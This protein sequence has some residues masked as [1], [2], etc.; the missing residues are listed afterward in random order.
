MDLE[1]S[2]AQAW[3]EEAERRDREMDLTGDTGVPAEDVL[4]RIRS[5]CSGDGHVRSPAAEG[6]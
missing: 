1:E 2:V 5:L 3:A 6:D 4:A